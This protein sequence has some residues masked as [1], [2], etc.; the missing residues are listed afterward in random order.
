MS[1]QVLRPG[2]GGIVI[3]TIP[4]AQALEDSPLPAI[5]LGAA[6]AF[7]FF[8]LFLGWAAFARLDA[9]ATGEG[10]VA[11]A[12]NRQ[13]M[14]HREGGIVS[15]IRVR[16]GAKVVAGQVLIE[17][18]AAD[19][20]AHERALTDSVI[21]LQAQKARLEAEVAGVPVKWPAAFA[22]LQGEDLA[23]AERAMQ[24]QRGQ[25]GARRDALAATH[26]VIRQ[27]E[28]QIAEQ[29]NGYRAQLAATERQRHSLQEQLE[30]TRELAAK[31]F[32]SKN[33]MRQIERTIAQFDG[34]SAEYRSRVAAAREQIGQV[35]R[36]AIQSQRSYVEESAT[37]LRETQFQL[38]ELLPQ[39]RAARDSLDRASIRAPVSGRIVNLR[40]FTVGG[41]ISPAQPLLDIVPDAAS[42]VLRIRFAPEDID[43]IHEGSEA[44]VKFLSLHDRDLPILIG[45]VRNVSADSLRDEASGQSYFAA[46]VV[47]PES[48]LALLRKVRPGDS[49]I[50]PGVPV[51]ASIRLRK[52]TA[53]QY[54]L[55][56][57]TGAFS[58]SLGER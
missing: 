39:L 7:L 44:E 11:V 17:L 3:A 41:V 40:V 30:G 42:L 43:G 50:R 6:A 14:Q 58:G 56:P 51:Q 37:L 46:E 47:V 26:G 21:N 33:Q 4:A 20:R 57:L 53:L 2:S 32:V 18:A 24:L 25:V 8:I 45:R 28:A 55:E 49:G 16:D 38:N 22:G 9:A 5:R 1:A 23:M 36:E 19:V 15:A 54:M 27:Q 10:Q 31:G 52:R 48:Q 13:T 12:G 34:T 35:R 29:A